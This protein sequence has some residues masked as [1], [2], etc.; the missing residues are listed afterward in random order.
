M[1]CAAVI[2]HF[3]VDYVRGS[4]NLPYLDSL[5]KASPCINVDDYNPYLYRNATA[6]PVHPES[7]PTVAM[8]KPQFC[9]FIC[10]SREDTIIN[11]YPYHVY[12]MDCISCDLIPQVSSLSVLWQIPQFF[13]VGV[14]EILTAISAINF[15][16]EQVPS[17]MRSVSQ[18]F[19]LVTSALGMFLAIPI[20]FIV[21]RAGR[22][23][24]LPRDLN[25]GRLADYFYL[26]AGF[27]ILDVVYFYFHARNYVEKT[28]EYVSHV[29]GQ[30]TKTEQEENLSPNL[31][32][33][34]SS[35]TGLTDLYDAAAMS[36]SHSRHRTS[37]RSMGTYNQLLATID[38]DDREEYSVP[39][40]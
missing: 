8:D 32:T 37:V 3:R 36:A 6:I 34:S 40:T 1:L 7:E 17:T 11:S 18:S 19:N 21:N 13:L 23:A 27:M 14:A 38:D 25:K 4:S 2:E 9:W 35:L 15:F 16:Y 29:G 10:E 39:F 22:E 30:I 33:R 28:S 12:T 5:S 24:W 20:L 26:L 31:R